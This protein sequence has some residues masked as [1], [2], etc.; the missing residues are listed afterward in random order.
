MEVF[1]FLVKFDT[2]LIGKSDNYREIQGD[3][4]LFYY[5]NKS[6]LYSMLT[7]SSLL[8]PSL[9]LSLSLSLFFYYY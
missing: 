9:S 1:S 3:L 4:Y 7:P 8:P 5:Y 2:L 6:V